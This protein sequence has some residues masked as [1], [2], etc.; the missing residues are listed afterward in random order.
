MAFF[1]LE[2]FPR[3]PLQ[4]FKT[5]NK[6]TIPESPWEDYMQDFKLDNVD[7]KI[8]QLLARLQQIDEPVI[9]DL[10]ASTKALGG[11]SRK[12]GSAEFPSGKKLKALAVARSDK[13]TPDIIASDASLGIDLLPGNL[14]TGKT[15]SDINSW[16]DGKK[17]NF[18]MERGLGFVNNVPTDLRFETVFISKVWEML[19]VGGI[20]LLQIPPSGVLNA[21]GIP[22]ELWLKKLKESGIYFQ[23]VD[24]YESRNAGIHYGLLLLEKTS[25][26]QLPDLDVS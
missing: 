9:I 10:A 14:R 1:E 24:S 6:W 4:T 19:E 16:L 12:L 20:A 7:G 5:E 26:I 23:H 22:I 11:L 15:W 8:D 13:R 2:Y 18:I 3:Y 17:A 25:E 21:R